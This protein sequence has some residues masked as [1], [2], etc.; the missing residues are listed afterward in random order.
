MPPAMLALALAMTF[1]AAAIRGLTGFGMAIILVPLLSLVITPLQA[2]V[3]GIL[4]QLYI[5]PVGWQRI[6]HDSE[7]ASAIPIAII[8]VVVTPLGLIL[9]AAM[10]TM[11]AT[12]LNE[13]M[14]TLKMD[15]IEK[16]LSG[17]TDLKQVRI[18]CIK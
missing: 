18:V 8:A 3:I 15:G 7:R 10:N 16:V 5:G 11:L 17:I 13:G 9:L 4:L 12:A 14:H 1:G 6:I 2:V